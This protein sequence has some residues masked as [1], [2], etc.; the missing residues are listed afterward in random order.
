[1]KSIED[2]EVKVYGQTEGEKLIQINKISRNIVKEILNFGIDQDHIYKII[3]LLSLELENRFDMKEI[4]NII[5]NKKNTSN[6]QSK[7]ELIF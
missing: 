1:M 7:E 2:N 6:N 5:K 3:H 4:I